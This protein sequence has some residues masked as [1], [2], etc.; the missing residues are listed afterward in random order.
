[1]VGYCAG[2]KVGEAVY[3]GAKKIAKAAVSVGKAAWNAVKKIAKKW[4]PKPV[5]MKSRRKIF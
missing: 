4:N 1:M 3:N 2:S 5:I